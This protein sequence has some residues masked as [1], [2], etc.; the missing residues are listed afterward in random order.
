LFSAEFFSFARSKSSEKLHAK[1]EPQKAA[2][3]FDYFLRIASFR[4]LRTELTAES[5]QLS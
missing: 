2:F 3:S 1:N 4:S 5:Q